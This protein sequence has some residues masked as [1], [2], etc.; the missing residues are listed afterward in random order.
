MYN[1][2]GNTLGSILVK[3]GLLTQEKL[4][5]I[6]E[7][8]KRDNKAI[9]ELLIE[10]KTISETDIVKAKGELYGIEYKSIRALTVEQEVLKLVNGQVLRRHN[11]MPIGFLNESK[12]VLELAMADPLDVV[13]VDD[14]SMIT[15]CQIEPRIC[16]IGEINLLIDKYYG[17][18]EAMNAAE[19]YTRE[20]ESKY[21]AQEAKNQQEEA[22]LASA[23]I[24]QLVRSIIEQ[25]VRQRASDIHIDAHETQVVVRFRIDGVLLKVMSYD[26]KLMP[27]IVTRIKIMGD[28][29]ISEKRKAQDGRITAT[30]DRSECDI[31]VSILPTSYGE[32]VVMRIQTTVSLS[33]TKSQLG[34]HE[35]EL[36]VFDHIIRN[37][38]GIILVTGPTGSGKSTTLYTALSEINDESINIITVEDPVE[39]N[40]AGINQVQVN[41]KADLTFANALR[42]IL[43][44]DPDV[45]MIGEIRDYETASIAVQASIT[46]HL[47]VSTLHTNS[48]AAT[49]TRLLD[50]GVDSFLVA[51]SVVGIIAQRLVRKL[52]TH[53]RKER[54]AD[55]GEKKLLGVDVNEEC[56]VYD[57][58]G[59]PMCNGT[60]FYGR[61]AVFEIM[62]IS[63]DIKHLISNKASTKEI[64]EKAIENGMH[65]L[66]MAAAQNVLDG[67]TTIPEMLK[68]SF[69]A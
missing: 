13:A 47:V 28:M 19:A 69:E 43:R 53:C 44:Q 64:K 38:N 55:N 45:I 57:S 31:R 63:E 12:D 34:M 2:D 39:A 65:T 33:R 14:I 21:A 4:G 22:D 26:I 36:E 30:V 17:T 1:R 41:N 6:I 27:V 42:A 11:V 51:D 16:A 24:V 46:G 32:K 7:V 40:I 56:V 37:P 61:T 35:W 54:L 59:C 29:D 50:M 66:R 3:K 60:G 15:G 10:V 62:R 48:S 5:E 67:V 9:E 23:P 52:C 20:R 58:V 68:V 8:C 18:D 49:I 25:A